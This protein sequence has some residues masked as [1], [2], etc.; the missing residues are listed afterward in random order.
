MLLQV[1][2]VLFEKKILK[3]LFQKIQDGWGK[4]GC[5]H[6]TPTGPY[7]KVTKHKHHG[8]LPRSAQP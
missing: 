4:G 2:Q 6:V 5:V 7:A 3:I 1:A 8:L